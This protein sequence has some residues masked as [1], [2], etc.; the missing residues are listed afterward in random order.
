MKKK[1]IEESPKIQYTLEAIKTLKADKKTKD[2]FGSFVFFG[3]MGVEYHPALAEYFAKYLGYKK[4]EV[5]YISGK[6]TDDQKEVIKEKFNTGEIKVL[7]G[8]DQTKE[9]ID[10]Q[11]NGYATFNLA[12]GWNPTLKYNK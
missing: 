3:K 4:S 10:L 11:N 1:L 2:Y 7:I 5:A 12:L 8:G 6:V 9:G